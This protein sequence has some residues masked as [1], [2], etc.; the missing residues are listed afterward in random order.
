MNKF[1]IMFFAFLLVISFMNAA[2]L[3]VEVQPANIGINTVVPFIG[4]HE[5]D[6]GQTVNIIASSFIQCP[7]VY[8]FDHW[9]GNVVDPSSASTTVLMDAN[10]SVTA[11]FTL[12]APVCG[13]QCHPNFTVGD[14]NHDCIVDLG[15]FAVLA[16]RWMNCTKPE[17]DAVIP[18][19]DTEPPLPNPTTLTVVRVNIGTQFYDIL[20]AGAA[21]DPSG[22]EYQFECLDTPALIGSAVTVDW[23]NTQNIVNGIYLFNQSW[24]PNGSAKVP[25]K[26]WVP[27]F[28]SQSYLYRARTRDQSAAQNT[29]QWSNTVNSLGQV[30]TDVMPPSPNP[31]Q[32][33]EE[34]HAVG[35][36]SI[37]MTAVT[38]TD[39]E[40]NGVQY[41]FECLEDSSLTSIWLSSP[42]FT[43]GG[44][45]MNQAYTFRVKYRDLSSNY[46]QTQYSSPK[47]VMI[48]DTEPPMPNP[49]A[50]AIQ[51]YQNSANTI[52]MTAQAAVDPEGN[53]VSYSFN[54]IEDITL[55]SG[56]IASNEYVTPAT[57]IAGQTYT[58]RVKYRDNSI[59]QNET[60]SS[61]AVAVTVGTLDLE[62]PT[63]NPPTISAVRITISGQNY[64][65]LT[66][67]A[68]MD[69]SGVEYQFECLSNSAVIATAVHVDWINS[70]NTVDGIYPFGSPFYPNAT[71]KVP[72][73]IWVP[74]Y[75]VVNYTYRVRTR[76]QSPAG[77]T[78]AW[79]NSVTTQ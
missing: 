14:L 13:D 21:V 75:S 76:D 61:D 36:D 41:C 72:N 78:S 34:P 73:K 48:T 4:V 26:I 30:V 25:N 19:A 32:W 59:N 40:G 31:A 44:I 43:L 27:V 23:I 71:M 3:T 24:Y 49:A 62:P 52:R 47:S 55:N 38:A 60:A 66:A 39:A 12:A 67:S 42:T 8:R 63:P 11:V 64:H 5:Y 1:G 16:S 56:W 79:S 57:L 20:T 6:A 15:D 35:S 33:L 2:T 54:C 74:V 46:N 69:P 29:G 10:K 50:W 77:N 53:G 70:G 65:V 7:S 45:T 28:S 51:P 37:A 58:F 68:V 9:T 22:V 18:P 17:C